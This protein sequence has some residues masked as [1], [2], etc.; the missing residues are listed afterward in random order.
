M[1]WRSQIHGLRLGRQDVGLGELVSSPP[2]AC[3]GPPHRGASLMDWR[4][5]IHGLRLGRQD[6]GL[7]GTGELSPYRLTAAPRTWLSPLPPNGGPPTG[8][9]ARW[10]GGARSMG[11][12]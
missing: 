9:R 1:D 5:Q 11:S 3:G 8:G 7:G 10:T 4:S 2:I 6:V 12:A